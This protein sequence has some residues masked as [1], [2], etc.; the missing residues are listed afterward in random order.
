MYSLILAK[1]SQHHFYQ[2][3]RDHMHNIPLLTQKPTK[4]VLACWHVVVKAV[5]HRMCM[6]LATK[7]S[8]EHIPHVLKKEVEHNVPT[9]KEGT[10]QTLRTLP[11]NN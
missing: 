4:H 8:Q 2:L 7:G 1:L 11:Q 6:K 9:L 10:L 5:I 3:L